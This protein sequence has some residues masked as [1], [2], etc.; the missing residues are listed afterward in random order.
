[1]SISAVPEFAASSSSA[2]MSDDELFREVW[3]HID[4]DGYAKEFV[5]AAI[6]AASSHNTQSWR[7]LVSD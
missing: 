1:M 5:R 7:F 2:P 6:L 4:P 3:M